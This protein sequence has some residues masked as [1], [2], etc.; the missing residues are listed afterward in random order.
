MSSHG[1]PE[2]TSQS[3]D[4][5]VT[6]TLLTITV[7]G[8]DFKTDSLVWWSKAVRLSQLMKLN[9]EDGACD[10]TSC[11]KVICGCQGT[12]T[13]MATIEKIEAQEERRRA[14]WLL[15]CLDRH[16]ALSF[17]SALKILDHE[18]EVFTPLPDNVWESLDTTPISVLTRRTHG[19]PTAVSGTGF[20]EYFLPLMTILGDVIQVHHQKCHPR[21]GR[22]DAHERTEMVENLLARCAQDIADLA[23]KHGVEVINGDIPASQGLHH[24]SNRQEPTIPPQSFSACRPR[25]QS[26]NSQPSNSPGFPKSY[27]QAQHVTS[28]CTFILHVLHVLLHGEWDAVFMLDNKDDWIPSVEFMKC[29]SHAIAASEAVSKILICDPEL[30]FMPY[31]FGIYLLHGSFV[32]LLFADRMP[33]IGLNESVEKACEIIIQAHEVC[34]V[35]LSTEFQV[36]FIA[37]IMHFGFQ[38]LESDSIF[39]PPETIPQGTSIDFVFCTER[40]GYECGRK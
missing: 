18:C 10:G 8:G 35:T 31:L 33:Q 37:E 13:T 29:A 15:F 39:T 27:A 28:Y 38:N 40:R 4:D 23:D 30:T 11:N 22:L 17:N 9:R 36:S 2:L 21:F 16:L 24:V 32:L 1:A 3:I 26:S 7:S 19:P 6:Y 5:V 12:D 34:V 14:F 20:F 25:A